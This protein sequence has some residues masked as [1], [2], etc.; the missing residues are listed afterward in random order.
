M[1]KKGDLTKAAIQQKALALF[2]EKG[3]K[4]VT[5]KDICEATGL[6][7]GGLY[8][9]YGSTRQIFAD[10]INEIMSGIKNE[11]T[12]KI[13]H[14]LSA[15]FILD[16][17]LARYQCEMLDRSGSLGLAFYEFYSSIPQSDN[18]AMLKQ[19]YH[20]KTMLSALIQYGIENGE[21]HPVNIHA[22]VDLLLFSYQG[23]RMLNSIMPLDDDQIPIG[24][25]NQIRTMLVK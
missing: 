25:I 17:L 19:Y 12:E 22:V 13:E 18:N 14:G 6:S 3:F 10:I 4:D 8:M 5:M 7:R 21:F 20:S 23:V 16:G 15:T 2:V 11:V 9:H 24:M 1:G